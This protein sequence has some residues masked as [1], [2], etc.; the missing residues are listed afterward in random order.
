MKGFIVRLGICWWL[1]LAE[2]A[3]Q[4]AGQA[5]AWAR[6]MAESRPT[7]AMRILRRVTFF[8]GGDTAFEAYA[9]MG[10]LAFQQHNPQA[11]EDYFQRAS[12]LAPS[13][14][15]R[16]VLVYERA[17]AQIL[18]KKWQTAL[19]TLEAE[20]DTADRIYL[21]LK[22]TAHWGAL[23]DS[24]ARAAWLR[25]APDSTTR[26]R[27]AT[28]LRRPRR[29]RRPSPRL[30]YYLSMG[31][32]GLGQ[33]YAGYPGEAVHSFLLVGSLASLTAYLA[34]RYSLFDALGSANW[35]VRYLY[36]GANKA[37]KLAARRRDQKRKQ[38]YEKVLRELYARP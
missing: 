29:Y 24:A 11:A 15:L 36:G 33:A 18:Q 26:S 4:D 21:I 30:A 34:F 13:D 17:A 38:L 2:A 1:L 32:P 10:R 35:A 31:V 25:A 27:I 7:E 9:L 37:E 23:N 20:G 5:L 16:K 22:G 8:S 3:A 14:S 6:T 19:W 12:L 28:L